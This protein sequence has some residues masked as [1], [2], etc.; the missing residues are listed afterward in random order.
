[1]IRF[2]NGKGVV[3]IGSVVAFAAVSLAP[4]PAIAA[5]P[6]W[7]KI[8]DSLTCNIDGPDG[9]GPTWHSDVIPEHELTPKSQ[10]CVC[11]AMG[12]FTKGYK[13]ETEAC[14]PKESYPCSVSRESEP[15]YI[16]N[17]KQLADMKVW[18]ASTCLG[19]QEKLSEP[20]TIPLSPWNIAACCSE[21]A[22]NLKECL[23]EKPPSSPQQPSSMPG[24]L[25][26]QNPG[27]NKPAMPPGAQ[28]PRP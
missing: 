17:Q 18:C 12:F 2:R 27:A 14:F 1:M 7:G 4:A 23:S 6:P 28:A 10:I 9:F 11:S 22:T 19:A 5:A 15:I 20:R 21:T 16:V 24:N 3:R 13:T 26:P 8:V 25:A